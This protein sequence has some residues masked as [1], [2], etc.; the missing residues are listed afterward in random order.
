MACV[1]PPPDGEWRL[2][3]NWVGRRLTGRNGR[4]PDVPVLSMIYVYPSALRGTDNNVN[5]DRLFPAPQIS[6]PA[7]MPDHI[8][9]R[10]HARAAALVGIALN[11]H[12]INEWK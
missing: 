9:A 1:T 12:L 11:V 6:S 5:V 7:D 2:S 10:T 8:F 3:D 4:C